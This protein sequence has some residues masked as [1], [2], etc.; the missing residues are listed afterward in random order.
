MEFGHYKS[1][2][3]VAAY[4]FALSWLFLDLAHAASCTWLP[5]TPS[6]WNQPSNWSDCASGNGVP[7]GTPGPA[8]RAIFPAGTGTAILVPQFITIAE[9]EMSAGT[10]LGL[11][12]ALSNADNRQL[13]VTGQAQLAGATLSGALPP[14]GGPSPAILILRI[15]PIASLT[16]SAGNT[17]RRAIIVNG[18]TAS[19]SGGVGARLDFDL[20]GQFLNEP[21][22]VCTTTGDFIYGYTTSGEIRNE[23]HWIVQGP[24]LA[25]INRSGTDG[26]RFTS[27]G[28]L[29]IRAGT[30][31]Q[32]NPSS[33]FQFSLA[34]SS[35]RL[36]NGIL[37]AGTQEVAII[38]NR[39]LTGNGSIIGPLRIAGGRVDLDSGVNPIGALSVTGNLQIAGNT[40]LV[41]DVDG[42][43]PAQHDRIS[44]TGSAQLARVISTVRL[45]PS[46]MP[47]IDTSIPIITHASLSNS[48]QPTN[49]RVLSTYP[50]SFALRSQA[51]RTD[52]RVVPTLLI[53]D[54]ALAE[55]NIG[56][57]AMIFQT[58]L[59]APTSEVVSFEYTVQAGTAVSSP[60]GGMNADFSNTFGTVSFPAGTLEQLI[61]VQIN[62]DTSIEGHEAFVL[63]TT[64]T[65]NTNTLQ[66]A[67]FGN[68]QKF[69]ASMEG[70]ILNDDGAVTTPYLLIAKE[71]NQATPTGQISFVRRYSTNGNVVDGWAT[72]MP[73]TFGVSA[74]GFCVAPNGD[75]LSTRF[76]PSEGVVRMTAAGAVRDADFGGLISQEESCATDAQGNAWISEA[77]DSNTGFGTLYQ[78]SAFG[79][80]LKSLSIPV[81]E[82]AVDWLEL[83]PNQC[84]LYYT[85]EDSDVRRFDVC[86]NTPMTNFA[87]ASSGPC[88]ALRQRSNGEVLLACRDQIQRFAAN[89]TSLG[90]Y[91]RESLGET[92]TTGFFALTLDPD[93]QSFWTGGKVSGRVVR[94]RIDNGEV[95]SSF[96]TG[97]G[98]VNG[99]LIEDSIRLSAQ[100]FRDGFE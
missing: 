26:G 86:T 91:S 77:T 28:L 82:R 25:Q 38:S 27:V 52:L 49:E 84:T 11:D 13:T 73:N 62:G 98:G 45:A 81:G 12:P 22:G 47:T 46:Y 30:L 70:R 7:T 48:F 5:A 23:G 15:N 54:S 97:T 31:K 65:S 75:V 14:P 8:D 20:N 87:T 39:F 99:L 72:L 17:L 2:L 18:G 66:N 90:T 63:N 24:G 92:D 51:T 34:Q 40:E 88:Y 68:G 43:L 33:G 76:G 79:L 36:V 1:V 35:L 19:L 4:H 85:S 55:G 16:L 32:L 100:V 89:G 95:L 69:S 53:A 60:A 10:S 44:V 96:S 41:L 80:R 67:S 56:T 29:E 64:N 21:T 6:D 37:D 74:T 83:D 94:A 71:T 78:V 58:K 59:S 9:L 42:A 57:Q 50:L 3:R 61:T 93:G